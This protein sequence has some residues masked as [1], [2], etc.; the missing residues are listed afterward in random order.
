[1]KEMPMP[2]IN[3]WFGD[4]LVEIDPEL[5]PH[6]KEKWRTGNDCID[7]ILNG[8]IFG[9][10]LDSPDLPSIRAEW[11][12]QLIDAIENP[13][14]TPELSTAFHTQWHVCHHLLRDLVEDDALMKD[15]AWS[16][17]P[18]YTGPGVI[19][20]RGENIDRLEAGR[21]GT[22]WSDQPETAKMFASGLNNEGKGGVILRTNAPAEAI[23]AAP[24]DHSASWLREREFTVDWRKL[25]T[26]D[27][28][29]F[30]TPR[31]T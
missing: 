25:T 8:D 27:R 7:H 28:V 19:L 14:N 10:L 4:T 22:A 30:F 12:A 6:A 13:P 24:S 29:Q 11:Q 23:I 31:Q 5:A 18:P 21:T 26:I 17:L 9:P 2:K 3:V 20:Y 16:W 15:L 1:M